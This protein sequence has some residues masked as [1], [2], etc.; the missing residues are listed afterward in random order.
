MKK[1]SEKAIAILFLVI[2]ILIYVCVGLL[3]EI[4]NQD[5][6]IE[7]ISEELE[8]TQNDRDYYFKQYKNYSELSAELENQIGIYYE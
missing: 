4:R 1:N 6:K 5:I 2:A 8:D 3:N 7:C